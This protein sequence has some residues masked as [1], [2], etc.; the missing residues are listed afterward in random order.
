MGNQNKNHVWV[1]ALHVS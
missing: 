1:V